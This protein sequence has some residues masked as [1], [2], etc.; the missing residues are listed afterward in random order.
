[1]MDRF[2][3]YQ[4]YDMQY[5]FVMMVKTYNN[6]EIQQVR[7]IQTTVVSDEIIIR[8]TKTLNMC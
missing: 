5:I 6:K 8:G 4:M 1:M 2:D 7:K 3:H